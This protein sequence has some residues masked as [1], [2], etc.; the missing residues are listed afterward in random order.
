LFVSSR[1]PSPGDCGVAVEGE[2]GTGGREA[3]EDKGFIAGVT[4]HGKVEEAKAE[5]EDEGY[6]E[7][8]HG[9]KML[10][11]WTV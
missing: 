11:V 4:K 2:V 7:G 3:R 6:K 1:S 9:K 8:G 10:H 5:A